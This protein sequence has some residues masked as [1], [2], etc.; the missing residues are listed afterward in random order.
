MMTGQLL[1]GSSP[2]V[3][4]QYQMAIL[5]LMLA[6]SF[7]STFT[8][9][10]LAMRHAVFDSHHRLTIN[11]II[12]VKKTELH[13]CVFNACKSFVCMTFQYLKNCCRL[14]STKSHFDDVK[15]LL[16]APDS[17]CAFAVA[18][19]ELGPKVSYE[20][21]SNTVCRPLKVEIPYFSVT[22]FNVMS[23]KQ[24]LF[25]GNGMLIKELFPSV[26]LKI[27]FTHIK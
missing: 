14:N 15:E 5:W 27:L 8:G 19:N 23:G 11:N 18:S 16:I 12:K 4:A 2:L 1:G 6:S 17:H 10:Q 21:L 9:L 7:L 13:I 26:R 3:A 25:E 20:I 22:N 24:Y